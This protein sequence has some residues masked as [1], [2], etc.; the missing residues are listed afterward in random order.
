M[1]NHNYCISPI[2]HFPLEPGNPH[3]F[4]L[5]FPLITSFSE[6][7]YGNENFYIKEPLIPI[8]H[9]LFRFFTPAANFLS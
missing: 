9:K 6:I 8:F 1:E 2:N 3:V 7:H 5:F 4:V